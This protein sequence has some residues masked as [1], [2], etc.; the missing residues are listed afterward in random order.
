MTEG[1]DPIVRGLLWVGT[2]VLAAILS[3]NVWIAASGQG[4]SRVTDRLERVESQLTYVS[5]LLLIP[6]E[7]RTPDAVA[8]CQVPAQTTP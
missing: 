7:E 3:I 5:C 8:T 6:D 2:F 4:V 1:A